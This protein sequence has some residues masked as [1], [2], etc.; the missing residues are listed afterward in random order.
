MPQASTLYRGAEH[1]NAVGLVLVQ[2]AQLH[3]CT[4]LSA[5]FVLPD[6]PAKASLWLPDKICRASPIEHLN[7][8]VHL[9]LTRSTSSNAS[10]DAARKTSHGFSDCMSDISFS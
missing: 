10:V 3:T 2:G 8:E 9:E 6:S 5:S 1:K 7:A 4:F